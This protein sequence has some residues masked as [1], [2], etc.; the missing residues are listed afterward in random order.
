MTL[1]VVGIVCFIVGGLIVFVFLKAPQNDL[2]Q[3]LTTSQT[4]ITELT[5]K[6]AVSEMQLSTQRELAEQYEK[7]TR[8]EFESLA[9][10]I[11]DVKAKTFSEQTE[12]NLD[13]LIRP[14]KERLQD[15]E[16]K[17]DFVYREDTK[18]RSSLKTEI[19]R[20]F[21]LNEQM[22]KEAANLTNALKGDS[23][24]QGD[25]GELVL[26]KI[27]E[28]SGLREGFEYSLQHQ[29]K[30]DAGERLR[31]DVIINLPDNKHVVVDSK[32]SLKA[33][34]Q[35]CS[36]DD[37][38]VKTSQLSLHL[39]SIAKHV[40]ELAGKHYDKLSGI[41]CPEFVFLF[42]PIEPAYLLAVQNDPELSARAWKKGIALVTST[43]LFTSLKTVASIWRLENQNK[44]AAEI[45]K[46]GARLYDKFVGFVEDIEK[47]GSIFETGHKH[48]SSAMAKLKDGPGNIFRK[49]ERLKELGSS[50]TKKIDSKF[51]E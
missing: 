3:Q 33:Y 29:S 11:L 7:R 21:K 41:N 44:N 24:F 50:P 43:T 14:L 16:R 13:S 2:K 47:I 18:D 49:I 48:Y 12:R 5:A 42:M 8:T 9:Q 17:V 25:W 39:N 32:V 37:A 38:N 30:N 36:S 28:S 10:K 51:L 19:E 46:E 27:L 31:P 4:A 20:L 34:E 6:L 15:F 26:E 45:A 40:D 23:K 22:S 1:L 35:Y